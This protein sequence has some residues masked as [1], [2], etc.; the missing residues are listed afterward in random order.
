M[1]P[2]H[3]PRPHP[4]GVPSSRILLSSIPRNRTRNPP[5]SAMVTRR[6][7][8]TATRP[9]SSPLPSS[10]LCVRHVGKTP[11]RLQGEEPKKVVPLPISLISIVIGIEPSV[12]LACL[13]PS[14]RSW[15]YGVGGAASAPRLLPSCGSGLEERTLELECLQ[16][17]CMGRVFRAFTVKLNMA[18]SI[19]S[20]LLEGR[21][22]LYISMR[23]AEFRGWQILHSWGLRCLGK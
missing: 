2:P 17:S 15:G 8:E 20:Q 22:V 14:R 19:V 6:R 9:P 21:L 3:R 18:R 4:R 7:R 1:P 12:R 23:G 10:H 13:L 16:L 11:T 5:P